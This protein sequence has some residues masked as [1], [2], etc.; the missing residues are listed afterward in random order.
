MSTAPIKAVTS[1]KSTKKK[2]ATD[3]AE[4]GRRAEIDEWLAA[5]HV[6]Y[7]FLPEVDINDI[8]GERSLRNQA[9][10]GEETVDQEYVN[11]YADAMRA[12]TEFP[13]V[14]VYTVKGKYVIIDGN[15]RYVAARSAGY[16]LSA[17]VV[18]A[19]AHVI[20]AMTFEAN[21]RHGK[22]TSETERVHHALYLMDNGMSMNEA[23]KRMNVPRG[24]IQK[25]RTQGEALRRADGAGINRRTW[26]SLPDAA[27][28]RLSQIHTDEALAAAVQLYVDAGLTA[29]EVFDLVSRINDTRSGKLQMQMVDALRLEYAERI[30]DKLSGS[31]PTQGKRVR[32]PKTVLALTLGQAASLPDVGILNE[33]LSPAER[34]EFLPRISDAI[35]RLTALRDALK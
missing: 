17:Y 32:S 8:D 12:G 14:V 35:K 3:V 21:V 30:Q 10:L 15:H 19:R 28:N 22:A 18:N 31:A 1:R 33:A 25:A 7:D 11:R 4:R 9:R 13:A 6:A 2:P 26:D 34:D 29:T 27:R 5:W 20:T 23:A 16:T 24:K